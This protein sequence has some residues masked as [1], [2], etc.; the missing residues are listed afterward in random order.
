M[1]KTAVIYY[2][3][4][5]HTHLVARKI[6]EC[7]HCPAIRLRLQQEFPAK[8]VFLKYFWAG[9]SSVF[10]DKPSLLDPGV[11]EQSYDTLIIATPVWA[12]NLSSPVRSFL[13]NHPIAGKR[14]F[15]VATNSGGSFDRCFSTMRKLL[16]MTTIIRQIGFVKISEDSY[17]SHQQEIEELCK[18]IAA[19][20]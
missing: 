2:S 5:G 14:V 6:A 12:G 15:L 10:R 18:E 20:H 3:L 4:D 1:D 9:K 13:A 7:L 19:M 11:D 17:P 16:S 8:P